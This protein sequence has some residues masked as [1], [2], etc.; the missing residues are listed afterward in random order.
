MI[1]AFLSMAI[2]AQSHFSP[3]EVESIF[4]EGKRAYAESRFDAATEAF[5]KLVQHG[6][7]N[8]DVYFNLGTSFLATG[9]HGPAVLNLE[10]ARRQ[11][12]SEDIDAQ[13]A[14]ARAH[15]VDSFELPAP[16]LFESFLGSSPSPW[17][18]AFLGAWGLAFLSLSLRHFVPSPW[19]GRITDCP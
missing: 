7:A 6:H 14:V 19:R 17:V 8:A 12:P 15:L 9:R 11:Q 16:P 4:A 3:S 10:L 5:G 13:L 2:L 18:W 1:C